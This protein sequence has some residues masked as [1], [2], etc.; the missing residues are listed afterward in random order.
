MEEKEIELLLGEL[1]DEIRSVL[2]NR[3]VGFYLYGSAATGGFEPG[4]SDLDLLAAT[5]GNLADD[6]ID[7]LREMHDGFAARYPEWA[8]RI[9]VVYLSV[10]ALGSF[11]THRNPIAVISPGEPLHRREEGAGSGWLMNW[12]LVTHGGRSLFGPAP[13]SFIT[14]TTHAEFVQALRQHVLDGESW[15]LDATNCKA[16]SYVI[17]TL[18]RTLVAINT[19]AHAS[20]RDA[21]AWVKVNRPRWAG[22][23]D[24]SIRSRADPDAEKRDDP[25]TAA[26]LAVFF[27]SVREE[28]SGEHPAS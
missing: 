7:R 15:M 8:D 25:A 20:K 19:G 13:T 14:P 11:K 26:E 18:C 2:R 16:Q 4:V 21:A 27:E 28:V 6:D 23:V 12:H 10:E 17:F 9:E 24:K 1:H 5:D 22:L 3:L